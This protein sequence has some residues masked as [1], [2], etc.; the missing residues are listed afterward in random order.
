MQSRPA[1]ER[2]T[3]LSLLPFVRDL[4]EAAAGQPAGAPSG[5]KSQMEWDEEDTPPRSQD[6]VSQLL[7]RVMSRRKRHEAA[8]AQA[9]AMKEGDH[10][11]TN[12]SG[13]RPSDQ[14][15]E[16]RNGGSIRNARNG[17]EE[18]RKLE[19]SLPPAL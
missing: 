3:R 13:H 17:I 12:T 9:K 5:P 6:K 8:Q 15:T 2:P 10:G 18:R 4:D 19:V 1:A 16:A 11:T 14:P 7:S